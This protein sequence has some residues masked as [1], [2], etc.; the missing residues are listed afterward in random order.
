MHANKHVSTATNQHST[1]E[2]LL[3]TLFLWWSMPRGYKE[4]NWSKKGQLEGSCHSERTWA[5]KQMNSHCWSHYQATTSEDTAGWKRLSICF[6]DMW[7]VEI[8]D[9]II[10]KCSHEFVLKWSINPISKPN[11]RW[12]SLTHVAIIWKC[13]VAKECCCTIRSSSMSK[14]K[15]LKRFKWWSW[16]E[17]EDRWRY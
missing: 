15:V 14:R 11:P 9:G 7:S 4:D 5:W 2:E 16:S 12:E 13:N 3:E 8:S 1:I 10:M 6:S 17:Q